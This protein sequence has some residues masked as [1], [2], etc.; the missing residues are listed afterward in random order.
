VGLHQPK[1]RVRAPAITR[2]ALLQAAYA[3]IHRLGFQ[4]ASVDDIVEESGV[5]KGA[6]YHHFADKAALGYAV[7]HE[8]VRVMMLDG[9]LG[10]LDEPGRDPLTALQGALR[11]RAERHTAVEIKLGCPLNNLTQEMSTLDEVMRGAIETTLAAWS[12]GFALALERGQA[13]GTVRRDVDARKI[14]TFLVA[15]IE[16]S[17]GIAKGARSR[18]LLRS[19]FETLAAYLE[20]L[21]PGSRRGPGL[22]ARGH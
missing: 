4:A 19:N 3:T 17:Y 18:A 7:V 14:A 22:P 1:R 9:W 11:Q 2:H 13:A 16:G 8:V 5:T 6:V 21:R 10:P 20:G 15:A 12:R